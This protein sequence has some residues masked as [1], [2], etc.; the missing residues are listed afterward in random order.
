MDGTY[1]PAFE[2]TLNAEVEI[3]HIN[4]DEH[5]RRRMEKVLDKSA[6]KPA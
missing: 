1:S 4:T 6:A 5:I 2:R 3:R